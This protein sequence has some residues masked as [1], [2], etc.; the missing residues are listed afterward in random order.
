MEKSKKAS[1][2]NMGQNHGLNIKI[3]LQTGKIRA[4]SCCYFRILSRNGCAYCLKWLLT[5]LSSGKLK[6]NF[7]WFV[8]MGQSPLESSFSVMKISIMISSS[9]RTL[10]NIFDILHG[11]CSIKDVHYSR[12]YQKLGISVWILCNIFSFFPAHTFFSFF[13]D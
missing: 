5:S 2:R 9:G 1:L 11:Y 10:L 7:Q 4:I 8:F 12:P 13:F 3:S 6:R